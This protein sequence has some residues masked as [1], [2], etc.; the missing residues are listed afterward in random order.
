MSESQPN[1]GVR[2]ESNIEARVI[3]QQD[4]NGFYYQAKISM[5]EG[6]RGITVFEC[7]LNDT[8]IKQ[9][10]GSEEGISVSSRVFEMIKDACRDYPRPPFSEDEQ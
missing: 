10:E 6:M 8:N 2:R 4:E 1:T 9:L 7:R 5:V 3:M